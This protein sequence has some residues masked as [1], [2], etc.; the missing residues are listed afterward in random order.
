MSKI[1]VVD[2]YDSFTYNL[3]QIIEEISKQKPDVIRNNELDMEGIAAYDFIFLSPGPG[4]P[5]E[6]GD[7]LEVIRR[8]GPTKKIMGVCLGLQAI[9]QVYG[10]QLKNLAKVF[11]GLQT[12][13]HLTDEKSPI[14]HDIEPNFQAGRYHSWVIDKDTMVDD[15]KTTCIDKDGEIMAAEHKDYKVYGVQFHPESILTPIGKNIVANFLT[16]G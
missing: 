9:G 13:M 7:L 12:E 6:A 5:E 14:F 11:H 16:R 1:L 15:L 10:C 2:N 4:I 8:Y 3:V